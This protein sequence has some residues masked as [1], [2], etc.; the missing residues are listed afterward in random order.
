MIGKNLYFDV[1][2]VQSFLLPG[3]YDTLEFLF[4]D[5]LVC[6]YMQ[7]VYMYVMILPT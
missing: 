6:M 2:F 4:Q 5:M 3:P 1:V 7:Y